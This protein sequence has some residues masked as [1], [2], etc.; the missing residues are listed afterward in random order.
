LPSDPVAPVI[1]VML[2]VSLSQSRSHKR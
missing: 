2:I 1:T